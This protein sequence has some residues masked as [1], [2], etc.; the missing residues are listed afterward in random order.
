LAII[1]FE[2]TPGK[3]NVIEIFIAKELKRR[4]EAEVALL[5]HLGILQN[6]QI[7]TLREQG[8]L[9]LVRD[10][11]LSYRFRVPGGNLCIR[12][13]SAAWP[14]DNDLAILHPLIKKRNDLKSSDIDH[15]EANL[16]ILKLRSKAE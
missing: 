12:L 3:R 15:S 4:R 8:R 1:Y 7:N 6:S 5:N 16:R 13:L 10:E 14:T 11:I 9:E 2:P